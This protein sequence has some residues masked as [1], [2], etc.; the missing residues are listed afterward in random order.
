[1]ARVHIGAY[2]EVELLWRG[3]E[4]LD[5]VELREIGDMR[6]KTM[7]HLQCHIG[8]DSLV[9][10]RHGGDGC[11]L[12]GPGHRLRGGPAQRAGSSTFSIPTRS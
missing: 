1:M 10:A 8:T 11:R 7:L 6:G 4:I 12:L 5:P 3:E 2:K 9:W